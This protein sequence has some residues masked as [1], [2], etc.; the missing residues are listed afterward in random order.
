LGGFTV[1]PISLLALII[2]TKTCKISCACTELQKKID[3][4]NWYIMPQTLKIVQSSAWHIKWKKQT[5]AFVT[6]CCYTNFRQAHK[7]LCKKERQ[8][9]WHIDMCVFEGWGKTYIWGLPWTHGKVVACWWYVMANA[10]PT[11]ALVGSNKTCS[12]WNAK[13]KWSLGVRMSCKIKLH[14]LFS[15][16]EGF[17]MQERGR[18][19]NTP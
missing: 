19:I 3:N 2:M 15:Q 16:K 9:N 8:H 12:T 6:K 14:Y 1:F 18:S 4:P 5:H 13:I 7:S 11:Q 10:I 17:K